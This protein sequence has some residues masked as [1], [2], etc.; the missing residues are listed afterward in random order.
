ML[1]WNSLISSILISKTHSITASKVD[2]VVL[3]ETTFPM[4][5]EVKQSH[6]S[7]SADRLEGHDTIGTSSASLSIVTMS[8][9][10][11]TQGIKIVIKPTHTNIRGI[12]MMVIMSWAIAGPVRPM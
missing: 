5:V 9:I 1:P 8:I 2:L 3:F 12:E 7:S 10:A 6:V 11:Q 4:A